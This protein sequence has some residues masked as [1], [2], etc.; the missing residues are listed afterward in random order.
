MRLSRYSEEGV[1]GSTGKTTISVVTPSLNQARYIEKTIRSVISQEGDFYIDYQVVDGGST[2]GSVDIISRLAEEVNSGGFNARC[3]GIEVRWVSEKDEGQSQAINKGLGSAKGELV[4]WIN[5][6]DYFLPGTFSKQE[7]AFRRYTD[8]M[9]IYGDCLVVDE[10][11]RNK[12]ELLARR[13]NLSVLL[14]IQPFIGR[15]GYYLPQPGT[16]WRRGVH[17]AIGFLDESFNYAMDAEFFLRAGAA[18]LRFRHIPSMLAAFRLIDGTKSTSSKTVFWPDMLEIYRRHHGADAMEPFLER[19]FFEEG[20]ANGYSADHIEGRK[21]EMLTRWG[22]LPEKEQAV[23]RDNAEIGLSAALLMLANEAFLSG[24]PAMAD[25][26]A[27]QAVERTP[28]L[29]M[30]PLMLAYTLNKSMGIKTARLLRRIRRGVAHYY[31]FRYDYR[32]IV[33]KFQRPFGYCERKK[34]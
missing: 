31:A 15:A 28:S 16:F 23:L 5:S 3:L 26:L 1:M 9:F 4:T 22:A 25:G 30:H 19:Y 27:M 33:R 32:Y 29:K 21:D 34:I 14:S 18:G 10:L 8:A 6:D 13:Y 17:D 24:E 20:V 11:D 12:W 7:A 2:D